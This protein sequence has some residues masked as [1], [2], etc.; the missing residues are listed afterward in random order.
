M[1]LIATDNAH[2]IA[3]YNSQIGCTAM[4]GKYI[5]YMTLYVITVYDHFCALQ[6]PIIQNTAH[7]IE[8]TIEIKKLRY[9]TYSLRM[10]N[11]AYSQRRCLYPIKCSFSLLISV[12]RVLSEPSL[13]VGLQGIL[14]LYHVSQERMLKLVVDALMTSVFVIPHTISYQGFNAQFSYANAHNRL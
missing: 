9:K 13:M 4:N 11:V 5:L 7:F 14:D 1:L 12:K 6:H 2:L 3:R 10:E 8:T